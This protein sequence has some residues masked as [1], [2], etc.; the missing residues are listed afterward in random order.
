VSVKR[1]YSELADSNWEFEQNEDGSMTTEQI[2][3]LVLMDIRAEL[4]KLNAA[5][6]PRT[7]QSMP[8]T[9]GRKKK[10]LDR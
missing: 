6:R 7:L 5:L 8:K 1:R 10:E 3:L 4:K 2:R 9:T